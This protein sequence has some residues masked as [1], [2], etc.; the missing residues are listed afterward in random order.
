MA[1]RK[2]ERILVAR[3]I[4]DPVRLESAVADATT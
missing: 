4:G 3:R 1:G 2:M